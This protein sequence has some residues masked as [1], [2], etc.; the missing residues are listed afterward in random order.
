[1]KK[2]LILLLTVLTLISV[3]SLNAFATP[4]TDGE[5]TNDASQSADVSEPSSEEPSSE[6]PSSEEP[7]VDPSSNASEDKTFGSTDTTDDDATSESSECSCELCVEAREKA[8]NESSIDVKLSFTTDNIKETLPHMGVGLLGVMIV[9]SL[10]AV[11]VV[12]LNKV[13][14]KK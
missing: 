12:I 1:M 5:A 4:S 11:V 2:F 3:L 13:S 9:L 8:A 7:S 6:E 14:G 10:I